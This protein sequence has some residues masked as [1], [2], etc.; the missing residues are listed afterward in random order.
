[1]TSRISEKTKQGK[2][3]QEAKGKD[4]RQ[5]HQD[6][7]TKN[8]TIKTMIMTMTM[9]MTITITSTSTS[10]STINDDESMKP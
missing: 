3:K 2:T 7:R 6:K 4:I 8:I 1:M 9:T 5:R 10:A